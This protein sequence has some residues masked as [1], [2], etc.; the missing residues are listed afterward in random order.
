[1]LGARVEVA[2]RAIAVPSACPCCGDTADSRFT[3]A[4]SRR[5]GARARRAITRE[6]DF[7]YCSRCVEHA[8]RWMSARAVATIAMVGASLTG[9][10]TAALAGA[11]AGLVA[12]LVV[13]ACGLAAAAAR[14]LQARAACSPACTCAG[15]AVAFRGWSGSVQSFELRSPRYAA[16]LAELNERSLVNVTPFLYQLLE[17]RRVA[18]P[19]A[20]PEVQRW[21]AA[22]RKLARLGTSGSTEIGGASIAAPAQ[23]PALRDPAP[24]LSPWPARARQVWRDPGPAEPP[25]SPDSPAPAPPAGPWIAPPAGPWIERPPLRLAPR[26]AR[27]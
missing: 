16:E 4:C 18:R 2:S 8:R 21:P 10:G 11:L 22:S 17:Q 9:A 27:R 12:A 13:L 14:R 25:A 23:V 20:I 15:P 26:R 19:L 7:P 24:S 3:V 1:M 5:I 6:H